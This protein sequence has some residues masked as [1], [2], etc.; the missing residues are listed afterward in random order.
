MYMHMYTIL[1]EKQ[2]VLIDPSSLE[3][4][5]NAIALPMLNIK[6]HLHS[7]VKFHVSVGFYYK[8]K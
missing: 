6:I 7:K 8:C 3:S 5:H 1:I 4:R 2:I